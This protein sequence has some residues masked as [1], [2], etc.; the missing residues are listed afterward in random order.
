[1]QWRPLERHLSPWHF[2]L[3][4]L[5]LSSHRQL[6]H[7]Q[8]VAPGGGNLSFSQAPPIPVALVP[9]T[10][11]LV[12]SVSFR[13]DVL[14]WLHLFQLLLLVQGS[15]FKKGSWRVESSSTP[16]CYQTKLGSI[17]PRRVKPISQ[18]RVVM[19]ESTALIAGAK[20]GVQGSWCSK[21]LN[22]QLTFGKA[23]FFFFIY[24][25]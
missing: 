17:C 24:F 4:A 8:R 2:L 14:G 10:E 16:C 7:L 20:Q 23:F 5:G 12:S 3:E 1:M 15:S 19:K 22:S 13:R 18:H 9:Q 25:Y 21:P 11:R 6:Q